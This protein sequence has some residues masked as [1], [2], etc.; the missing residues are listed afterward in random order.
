MIKKEQIQEI[1]ASATKGT[2]IFIVHIS[3]GKDNKIYVRVDKQEGITLDEC[4]QINRFIESSLDR[5]KEDFEL[6]VSSPGLGEPFKV[7]PQFLKSVGRTISV[8]DKDGKKY[9]GLLKHIE[10]EEITLVA[11]ERVKD[12]KTKKKISV[13]KEYHFNINNITAKEVLSF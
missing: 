13:V 9:T 8:T 6:E 5:E 4:M 12:E 1:V 2:D 11:E 7:V 3:V 10:N